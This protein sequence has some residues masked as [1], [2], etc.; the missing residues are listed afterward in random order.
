MWALAASVVLAA[1][2]GSS[3]SGGS[4]ATSQLGALNQKVTVHFWEAMAGGSLKPTLEAITNQF[5]QSQS[6]VTV[7]LQVYPDYGT[8]NTKTLAALAAGTP[9]DLAQSYESWAAKYNQSRAIVDLAPYI[10]AK[11]GLSQQSLSDIFPVFLQDGKLAGKQYMFPFN[12]SDNVLFYNQER[13]QQAGISGPPKTWDELFADAQKLTGSGGWGIDAGNAM[14]GIFESMVQDFGGSLLNK[15]GTKSTFNGSAGQK[16]LQM[17]V[18]AVRNGSAHIIPG[19]DD[20]DF[21][22]G[23]EAIGIG[24]I[25]GYSFKS[26][27]VG[28]KFTM[29]T[30]AEPAGANGAHPQIFGTNV[31]IFSKSSPAVQQGAF[32]YVKYFTE[33]LQTEQWSEKTGY[34]PV[35]QSAYNEMRQS[36]YPSNMNLQVAVP[37][38]AHGTFSPKV[39][40]WAE[41]AQDI[42]NEI[43]NALGGKKSV[44]QAL[45]DAAGQ[46]DQLLAGA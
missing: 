17:W 41:A 39:A 22:A 45:D 44:K 10:N 18:D 24:T 19:Y 23:K 35:R 33:K 27:A 21:G 32:Q 42:T 20:S 31:V 15:D 26:Q 4:T 28:S 2:C 37:Q 25:A 8:L 30:G 40:S 34:V 1:A 5:N 9:P 11:D 36:F 3:S 38:L 7:Q 13:F 29:K 12:K 14:E 46:V 6:N 43:N 16:A